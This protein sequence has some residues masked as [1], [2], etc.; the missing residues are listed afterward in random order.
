[1]CLYSIAE[2][3][4]SGHNLPYILFSY[5]RKNKDSAIKAFFFK[6]KAFVGPSSPQ[7][8][9]DYPPPFSSFRYVLSRKKRRLIFIFFSF[10][11]FFPNPDRRSFPRKK[12]TRYIAIYVRGYINDRWKKEAPTGTTEEREA[13]HALCRSCLTSSWGGKSRKKRLNDF[14]WMSGWKGQQMSPMKAARKGFFCLLGF[15]DEV[16]F[17]ETAFINDVICSLS[18]LAVYCL[19]ARCKPD[20]NRGW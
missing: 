11:P 6:T 20:P 18:I 10:S 9:L 15:F 13:L 14:F 2:R 3:K 16:A 5:K 17:D 7:L 1:M 4:L 8:S 12:G 19:D